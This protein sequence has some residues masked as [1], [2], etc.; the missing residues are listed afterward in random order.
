MAPKLSVIVSSPSSAYPPTKPL[1][2][3][4]T[5][6]TPLKT[7][8]FEGDISVWIKNYEGE[9]KGGDGD[10]YFS[11]RES[12]TY[13]IIIRGKSSSFPLPSSLP[14]PPLVSSVLN[15]DRPDRTGD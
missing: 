8:H 7:P 1:T 14:I 10:E 11:E 3:N 15:G 4:S 12:M 2:V 9:N 6:P 13:S 5:T